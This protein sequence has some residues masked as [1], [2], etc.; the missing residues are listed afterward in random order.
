MQQTTVTITAMTPSDLPEVLQ[1]WRST[2]GVGVNDVDTPEKLAAYLHRNPE[3]SFVARDV[4][5]LV[6]AVLGGTDGRRGYL[7]HLAVADTYRRRGLGRSLVRRCLNAL[8]Q[9]GYA[10]CNIMVY[11]DNHE[12]RRFWRQMGWQERPD[13]L[14]MSCELGPE[15]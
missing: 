9:K 6:A 10:R 2:P 3:M 11:A 7:H 4:G 5:R 1:L 13:I 8:A 15:Q 14:L 12:G